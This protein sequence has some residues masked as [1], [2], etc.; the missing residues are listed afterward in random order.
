[1]L[2][3][4]SFIGPWA[5]LPVPWTKKNELDEGRYRAD[6]ARCCKAGIP[7]IYSGGTT[8][9]FYAMD[10][11]EFK[12]VARATVEECAAHHTPSMIGCTSTST[13]GAV[14]RAAYAAELGA[15]AI[16]V[17]LPFWMEVP[18]DKVVPFFCE[19]AQAA[20]GLKLS[21]YETLR[22]KKSL[23]LEQ[24]RAIKQAIPEY[25]MVKAN[26]GTIGCTEKGCAALSEWVHVFVAEVLWAKLG[27][28]GADGCCS[29][30]V[31]YNPRPILAL[32]ELL[33]KKDWE[34]LDTA[35]QPILQLHQFLVQEYAP[36]GFTDTA[37]D[38]MGGAAAG[39][40]QCG[41]RSRAPY[42]QASEADAE[43]LRQWYREHFPEMLDLP[44]S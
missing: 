29:A 18:D 30:L 2:N 12:I 3:Y 33:K 4:D 21:I 9:E 10:W 20:P 36:R 6:I 42:P 16:Q 35:I 7:G 22:A 25:L 44:E 38:H 28:H 31:Y 24:H 8:G 26:A 32:W 14:R 27:P 5:G 37:Y 43:R 19:V 39:F 41:L 13:R 23:G 11:D 34:N 1:M 17:A 40:L 15:D